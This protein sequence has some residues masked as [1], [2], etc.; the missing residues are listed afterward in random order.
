MSN[1]PF[2]NHYM[3]QDMGEHQSEIP[4]NRNS[5]QPPNLN[6]T[7]PG[8]GRRCEGGQDIGEGDD[9]NSDSDREGS[10]SGQEGGTI[11]CDM[12]DDA[13]LDEVRSVNGDEGAEDHLIEVGDLGLVPIRTIMMSLARHGRCTC[14]GVIPHVENYPFSMMTS[15]TDSGI[16]TPYGSMIVEIGSSHGSMNSPGLLG[17]RNGSSPG[18][19]GLFEFMTGG[20]CDEDLASPPLPLHFTRPPIWLTP[21]HEIP[22]LYALELRDL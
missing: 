6:M 7:V 14:H 2:N 10:P 17:H 4:P 22:T 3:E 12:A 15:P 9:G 18:L 1:P 19:S 20:A 13:S 21:T 8:H 16:A 5:Q 11:E